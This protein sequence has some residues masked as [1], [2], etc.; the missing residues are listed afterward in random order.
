MVTNYPGRLSPRMPHFDYRTPGAYFVTAC[1]HESDCSF[2]YVQ[3]GAV[4]L[5]E[6]GKIARECWEEI[7][8]HCPGVVAAEFVVMPNH[9]HGILWLPARG[10]SLPLTAIVGLYKAAVTRRA[11]ARGIAGATPIWQRSFHDRVIRD[12][13]ALAAIRDYIAN[14]PLHWELDH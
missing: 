7:P 8:H 4:H 9:I 14:N 3:D 11:R 13:A 6:L 1:T 12:A 10:N 2:G 5:D